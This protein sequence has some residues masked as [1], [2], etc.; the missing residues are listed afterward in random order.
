MGFHIK[1]GNVSLT[2]T[3]FAKKNT[4]VPQISAETN[5]RRQ[6]TRRTAD[7][8]ARTLIVTLDTII[9]V[10]MPG[11]STEKCYVSRQM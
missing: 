7:T 5:T 8:R 1:F 6:K 9:A 2:N 11:S 4:Q 10:R 3:I